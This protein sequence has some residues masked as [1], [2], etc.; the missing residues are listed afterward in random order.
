[1]FQYWP[2]GDPVVASWYD[3]LCRLIAEAP[4]GGGDFGEIHRAAMKIRPGSSEDWFTQWR[5]LADAIAGLAYRALEADRTETARA[6][7]WRATDEGAQ[8]AIGL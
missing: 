5:E 7:R 1:L 8:T 2:D 6:F 3:Q 4:Y